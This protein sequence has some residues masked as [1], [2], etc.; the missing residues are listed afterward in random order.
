ME[1]RTERKTKNGS[2]WKKQGD[3]FRIRKENGLQ[4][5]LRKWT[6]LRLRV[7]ISWWGA[8]N[9]PRADSGVGAK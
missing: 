2:G 1:M 7:V 6:R 4:E 8:E 9:F 3:G 5:R